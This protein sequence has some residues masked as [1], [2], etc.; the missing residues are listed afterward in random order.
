MGAQTGTY[1]LCPIKIERSL[2]E[3]YIHRIE[4][5]FDLLQGLCGNGIDMDGWPLEILHD[6]N[7]IEVLSVACTSVTHI[8]G[9]MLHSYSETVLHTFEMS[10]LDLIDWDNKRR[11]FGQIDQRIR[12]RLNKNVGSERYTAETK[13]AEGNVNVK[14]AVRLQGCS[15]GTLN[16]ENIWL[17]ASETLSANV[18][19]S[20]FKRAR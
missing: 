15:D 3:R 9:F 18:L 13:L 2:R 10:D 16:V 20:L 6:E 5:I 7:K 14:A 19:N 11:R 17:T 12:R 1:N 8:I 4:P